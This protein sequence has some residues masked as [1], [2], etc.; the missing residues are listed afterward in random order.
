MGR[1]DVAFL[2]GIEGNYHLGLACTDR[3]GDPNR[4]VEVAASAASLEFIRLPDRLFPG[5][6]GR[7]SDVELGKGRQGDSAFV[8]NVRRGTRTNTRSGDAERDVGGTSDRQAACAPERDP[9][10]PT[11]MN[12][13]RGA[14]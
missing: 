8:K 5:T 13:R 9:Q 4:A 2:P 6:L 12:N 10:R 3:L 14:R 1:G 11:K 7:I